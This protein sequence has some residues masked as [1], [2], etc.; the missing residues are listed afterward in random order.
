VSFAVNDLPQRSRI[1]EVDTA[2]TAEAVRKLNA[3]KDVLVKDVD[4]INAMQSRRHVI[5]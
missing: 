3:R 4:A 2:S 1:E 5:R